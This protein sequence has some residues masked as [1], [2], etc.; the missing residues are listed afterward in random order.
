ML[1]ATALLSTFTLIQYRY[2]AGLGSQGPARITR[3]DNRSEKRRSDR[4]GRTLYSGLGLSFPATGRIT[5]RHF[6]ILTHRAHACCCEFADYGVFH[7]DQLDRGTVVASALSAHDRLDVIPLDLR[8]FHLR[9]HFQVLSQPVS[10]GEGDTTDGTY[11]PAGPNFNGY[12][13]NI[14]NSPV[15]AAVRSGQSWQCVQGN[16][17]MWEATTT[18]EA[19]SSGF[20]AQIYAYDFAMDQDEEFWRRAPAPWWDYFDWVNG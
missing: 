6:R 18:W 15:F 4:P 11:N 14:K 20:T 8:Q 19:G 13:T 17:G 16:Q 5:A 3:P 1:C 9:R 7:H 12:P 2:A 10:L